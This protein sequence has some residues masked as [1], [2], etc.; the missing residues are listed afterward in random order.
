MESKDKASPEDIGPRQPPTPNPN[1]SN[2]VMNGINQL[3]GR[4]DKLDERL[5][6]VENKISKAMG[7]GTAMFF[8]LI[9][10]QIV[11]KFA[12]ISISIK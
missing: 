5:R 2:W 4:I 7:W 12:D 6:A 10:I 3:D 9:V 11:L 8:L 1:D